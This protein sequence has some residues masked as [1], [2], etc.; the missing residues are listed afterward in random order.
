MSE[1]YHLIMADLKKFRMDTNNLIDKNYVEKGYQ[2]V[3][4]NLYQF[5][6]LEKGP[7]YLKRTTKFDKDRYFDYS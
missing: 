7:I 4:Q 1:Y 6:K 5:E 2:V 3:P